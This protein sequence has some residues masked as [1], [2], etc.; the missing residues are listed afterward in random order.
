MKAVILAA[1][2]G[3]R[4]R[5]LTKTTPKPL[6]KI[7]G[8][9]F[10]EHLLDSF[11]SQV[12]EI[13]IIVGYRGDDIVSFLGDTYKG[14]KIQYLHQEK[15]NGTGPALLLTK[16]YFKNKERFFIAYGDEFV[17]K[18]EIRKCLAH[19]YSWLVHRVDMP[20]KSGIVTLSKGKIIGITEKPKRPESDLAAG[21]LMLVNANIFA[22]RPYRHRTG[23]Y[24]A[25]SMMSKFV[26][27]H[28]V[29]PV[30]GKSNLYFSSP[31]DVDN[32]NKKSHKQR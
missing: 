20:E 1:G 25:T 26:K 13:I 23:E 12:N 30:Y 32:F 17:T 22:Y 5:H 4:M 31:E 29:W 19:R 16:P 9:T 24:Y 3:R 21:G 27:K 7:R 10:L 11:P 28:S 6:I 18:K 15:L 8:K 14:K 2:K